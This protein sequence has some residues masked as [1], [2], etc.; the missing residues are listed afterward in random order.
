MESARDKVSASEY[1]ARV[2]NVQERFGYSREVA[3]GVADAELMAEQKVSAPRS[4]AAQ[5]AEPTELEKAAADTRQ[6]KMQVVIFVDGVKVATA[7][8][9]TDARKAAEKYRREVRPAGI[10]TAVSVRQ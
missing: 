8:R 3:E 7:R 2:K 4:I 10:V 1:E 5:T 6:G 9:M